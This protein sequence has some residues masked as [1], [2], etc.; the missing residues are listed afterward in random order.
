MS[1]ERRAATSV[2]ERIA[3]SAVI[4]VM[5]IDRMAQC[6][7]EM[8]EKISERLME[9]RSPR[10][11]DE[12]D[13]RM[14]I[15]QSHAGAIIGKGGAKISEL[16]NETGAQLKVFKVCRICARLDAWATFESLGSLSECKRFLVSKQIA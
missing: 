13:L 5:S 10:A 8:V 3:F 11:N 14:L 1:V 2:F 4:L 16:R 9:D 12:L 6:L 7:A 15:H